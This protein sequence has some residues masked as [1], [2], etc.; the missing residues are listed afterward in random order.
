MQCSVNMVN[1]VVNMVNTENK[2][3][4]DTMYICFI[5]YC[6]FPDYKICHLKRIWK[7]QRGNMKNIKIIC[8]LLFRENFRNVFPLFFICI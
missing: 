5:K 7:T 1:A 8:S 3:S 4:R 6:L 2:L